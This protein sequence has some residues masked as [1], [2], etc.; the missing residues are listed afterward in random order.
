MKLLYLTFQ[1]N[2]PLYLGVT[3]KIS[4]QA[5]AF[6]KLGFDVTYTLWE[7]DEFCFYSG[8][9]TSTVKI[10]GGHGLMHRFEAAAE[11]YIASHGFDV[12]YIRL[13][14]ISFGIINLCRFAKNNGTRYVIIEIPNYPYLKDYIRNINTV[15]PF[16]RRAANAVKV[17]G[18]AAEDRL[19]GLRLKGVVDAA[20]LIG[21]K[22]KSFF[23]VKAINISNGI[24][25]EEFAGV[26]RKDSGGVVLVSVAG[27]LWW[28]AYDRVLEGMSIYKKQKTENDPDVRFILVGGDKKEMPE[29]L[30]QVKKYGLESD[31]ECP[32]FKTGGQLMEIYSRS[33]AGV[34]SLGCYRRGLKY[35]SSLKAREYCAAGIP[36]IYAYEDDALQNGAPF[37]MKFPNDQTPI[38]I[39]QVVKFVLSC[40]ED[41]SVSKAEIDFARKNYDWQSI[42]KRVLAFAGIDIN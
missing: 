39:G 34:S 17:L 3:R 8:G 11:N 22:N 21:D 6:E 15:K 12:L 19:S 27:T 5:R 37:A 41:P 18:T 25:A 28:Q 35:C 36:F 23:G 42:M 33:D 13:D 32:G 40:R 1:E 20:V 29:F 14:R 4:G 10:A 9:K 30:D 2:A 7:K 31:V 26:R 38:D 16:K 24:N